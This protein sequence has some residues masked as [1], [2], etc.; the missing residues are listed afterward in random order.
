MFQPLLI[1]SQYNYT[2]FLQICK[3]F[4]QKFTN[5]LWIIFANAAILAFSLNS[6]FIM[7]IF[8]NFTEAFSFLL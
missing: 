2:L 7:N 5:F 4:Q 8:T 1:I 3:H 6:I